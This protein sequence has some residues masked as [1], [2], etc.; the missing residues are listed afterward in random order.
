MLKRKENY[1]EHLH[2]CYD[3]DWKVCLHIS[4]Q[5]KTMLFIKLQ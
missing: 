5:K 1:E 4:H 3:Y 2:V